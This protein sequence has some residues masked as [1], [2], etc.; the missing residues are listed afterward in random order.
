MFNDTITIYNLVEEKMYRK[1]VNNVFVN[2]KTIILQEGKG[3]KFTSAHDVIFSDIAIR[4]YL[5]YGDYKKLGN[6]EN[7]FTLK[8]NDVVVIGEFKEVENL[9]EIQKSD[10]E[11]FLIK[12]IS[13][14]LYGA[15]DLQNIEVTD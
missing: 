10:K 14:N 7:N 11:Y 1:V 9:S 4:D 8:V 15:A 6:K 13:K 2:N 3:E 12:T 5:E